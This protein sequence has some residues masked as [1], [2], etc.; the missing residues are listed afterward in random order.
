MCPEQ[1]ELNN[2]DIDT[3]SDVY[4]LG[5]LLYELLTGTTPMERERFSRLRLTDMLRVIREE[6]SPKPSTRLSDSTESLP[7]DRGERQTEPARLPKLVRG[8]LDWI[9][10]KALEKDRTRRYETANG[11]ATD[12]ERYLHDEPVL[13]CPPSAGLPAEEVPEAE[14]GAGDGGAPSAGPDRRHGGNNP[15]MVRASK[16]GETDAK[17]AEIQAVLDFVENKILASA[18]PEGVGGGLGREITLQQ[19]IEAAAVRGNELQGSAADRSS[20][21]VHAGIVVR[22]PGRCL[23]SERAGRAV[24]EALQSESGS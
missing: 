4:S 1:A 21:A 14:Q 16:L 18:R 15:G 22:L 23:A 7:I 3:R 20:L 2:H 12:I 8:E 13:A 5:V 11:F 6:E 19:A 24:M 10:M 17:A 9:A